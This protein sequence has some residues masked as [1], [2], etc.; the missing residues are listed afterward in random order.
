MSHLVTHADRHVSGAADAIKLD[1]LATPDDNTDLN[2]T[3]SVHGLMPKGDKAKVDAIWVSVPASAA[4]SGTA[5]QTA[6]DADYFYVCTATNTW[7]RF[8]KAAW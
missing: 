3:A 2:A 5:G 7:A 1:D 6:Y 8:A 4:A